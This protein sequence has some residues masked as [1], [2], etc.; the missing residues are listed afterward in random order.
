MSIN[1]W[2]RLSSRVVYKTPW[3]KVREDSVITPSGNKGTYSVIMQRQSVFIVAVTEE[4]EVYLIDLY[5]YTTAM[6]SLEVP[7]GGIEPKEI[8]LQAA[9]R[10][11]QEETGLQAKRWKEI[12]LIQ[13]ENGK[14]D[15][16]GH[17]FVAK[18]LRK[19][20][21]D[22]RREEGI[23]NIKIVPYQNVLR[24]IARGKITDSISISALTKGAL[25]LGIVS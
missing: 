1:K 5:R 17:V 4:N 18:T 14:S 23:D 10:E 8:P 19:T 9:K 11:L 12:G 25:H 3:F 15:A 6:G 24:M 20:D 22:E 7:G 2:K 16:I 13:L 21:S